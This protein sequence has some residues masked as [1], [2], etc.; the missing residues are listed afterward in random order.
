MDANREM[1]DEDGEDPF[2]FHDVG[3]RQG[4]RVDAVLKFFL[5]AAGCPQFLELMLDIIFL[6]FLLGPAC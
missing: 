5:L 3:D 6:N 4:R 2:I 1:E